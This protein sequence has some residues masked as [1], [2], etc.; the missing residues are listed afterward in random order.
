MPWQ[1]AQQ[2]ILEGRE[3]FIPM[4]GGKGWEISRG[5]A[6]RKCHLKMFHNLF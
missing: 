6:S 4:D 5:G 2:A 3:S 1:V